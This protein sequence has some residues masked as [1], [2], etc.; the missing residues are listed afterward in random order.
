MITKKGQ[1][2]CKTACTP[3]EMSKPKK[4]SRWT[5]SI[6]ALPSNNTQ[7]FP[8]DCEPS[9]LSVAD[10]ELEESVWPSRTPRL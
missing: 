1:H 6:K 5:I 4:Q 7:E 3:R 8:G 2:G 9:C 10:L